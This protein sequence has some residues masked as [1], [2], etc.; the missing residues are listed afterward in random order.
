MEKYP[1]KKVTVKVSYCTKCNGFVT[2]SALHLMDSESLN[3]FEKEVEKYK[4]AVKHIPLTE[5]AQHVQNY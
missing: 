4:L 5:N 3:R 1:L 2:A